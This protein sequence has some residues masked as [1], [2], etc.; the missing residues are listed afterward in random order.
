ML[1]PKQILQTYKPGNL[2]LKGKIPEN[3]SHAVVTLGYSRKILE[4]RYR[5]PS[6]LYLLAHLI[7]VI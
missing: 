7:H 6:Y 2:D 4:I 1:F 3:P 5:K